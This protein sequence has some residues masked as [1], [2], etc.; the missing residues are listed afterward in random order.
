[1]IH[2][3][4]IQLFQTICFKITRKQTNKNYKEELV[5]ELCYL[6]ITSAVGHKA[7]LIPDYFTPLSMYSYFPMSYSRYLH[8]LQTPKKVLIRTSANFF[9]FKTISG[10]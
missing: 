4:E 10:T 6:N 8:V 7:V 5:D 1:M 3:S 9:C 2:S